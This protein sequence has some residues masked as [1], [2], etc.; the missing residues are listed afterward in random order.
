MKL[1]F[2]AI[3]LRVKG[4]AASRNVQLETSIKKRFDGS[5]LTKKS[6]VLRFLAS[7]TGV[8]PVSPP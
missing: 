5:T 4:S 3:I 6:K 2:E 1:D 7:R 8:E